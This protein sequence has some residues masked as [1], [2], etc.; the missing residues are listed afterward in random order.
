MFYKCS[1]LDIQN[2]LA[3]L[4]IRFIFELKFGDDPL[5]DGISFFMKKQRKCGSLFVL[6]KIISMYF[7]RRIRE[8]HGSQG[9]VFENYTSVMSDLNKYLT[10]EFVGFCFLELLILMPA[11][12]TLITPL[13][14]HH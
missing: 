4:Q 13:R 5:V 11:S 9:K 10:K 6:S 2:K 12:V 14:K 8:K 3:N 7:L 1:P